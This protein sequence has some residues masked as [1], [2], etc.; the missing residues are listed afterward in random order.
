MFL[1][2]YGFTLI[3]LLIVIS[4]IA[5]LVIV[6]IMALGAAR[7]RAR[8]GARKTDL[9]SL[10]TG[11]GIY[12]NVFDSY[13]IRNCYSSDLDNCLITDHHSMQINESSWPEDPLTNQPENQQYAY[14]GS[15]EDYCL[16]ALLERP[17]NE[18]SITIGEYNYSVGTNCIEGV[19]DPMH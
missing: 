2:K 12:N 9:R 1:K 15:A 6:S 16:A 4:I 11:L 10:E 7:S 3:E 5:I 14:E 13:P 19:I 18:P 8:D 17:P